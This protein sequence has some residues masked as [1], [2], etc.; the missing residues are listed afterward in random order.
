MGRHASLLPNSEQMLRAAD[1]QRPIIHRI[2]RQRA[3]TQFVLRELLESLP[4]LQDV[5]HA[6]LILEID[7]PPP[8]RSFQ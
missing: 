4:S 5:A 2:A 3:L 6:F 7:T 8:R 1:E